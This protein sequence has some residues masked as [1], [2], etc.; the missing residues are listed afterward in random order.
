MIIDY[1]GFNTHAKHI[2]KIL[3]DLSL[4]E[5]HTIFT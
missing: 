4:R 2:Q 1:Y 5:K 3:S